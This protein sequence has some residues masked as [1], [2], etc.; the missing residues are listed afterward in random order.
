M[1]DSTEELFWVE[2]ARCERCGYVFSA[3]EFSGRRQSKWA[4]LTSG[5]LL[6]GSLPLQHFTASSVCGG[7][8]SVVEPRSAGMVAKDPDRDFIPFHNE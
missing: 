1:T 8:V 3:E 2:G 7:T 6:R 4:V 5:R